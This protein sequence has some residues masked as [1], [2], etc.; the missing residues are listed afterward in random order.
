MKDTIKYFI[1]EK[2][3]SI[4]LS[5]IKVFKKLNLNIDEVFLI[6]YFNNEYKPI[7]DPK[8]I[9]EELNMSSDDVL[10]TFN[11]LISKNLITIDTIKDKENKMVEIINLDKFYEEVSKIYEN[12][13]NEIEEDTIFE[14]FENELGRTLSPME[15]EIINGWISTNISKDLIIGALKEAV[16]N[17]VSNFRYIDKI[18]Y[19]WNKKGFKTM[20]DV[21]NHLEKKDDKEFVDLFDYDW[22]NDED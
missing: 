7:F 16:Y 22:L 10:N 9:S 13:K 1:K 3:Y 8:K 12:K 4:S 21:H 19:E 17:G 6:L 14:V 18:I 20:K 15:Y 5:F 2:H 11:N